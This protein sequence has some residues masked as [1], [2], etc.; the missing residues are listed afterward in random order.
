MKIKVR[1]MAVI[2]LFGISF[3]SFISIFN[4]GDEIDNLQEQSAFLRGA[5]AILGAVTSISLFIFWGTM[6]YDLSCR[7][8]KSK[9]LK[10]TWIILM[11]LFSF[12]GSWIYY[13]VVFQLHRNYHTFCILLLIE[14]VHWIFS[15][16]KTYYFSSCVV[17]FFDCNNYNIRI[18]RHTS[19][20]MGW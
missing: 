5:I 10:C 11:T 20:L 13:I 2:I 16:P 6:L 19:N 4:H 15:L 18:W 14:H 7:K 8:F 3:L 12:I 1:I 17:V 9:S